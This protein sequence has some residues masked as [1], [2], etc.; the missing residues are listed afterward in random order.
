MTARVDKSHSKDTRP[1]R[2]GVVG[3]GMGRGHIQAYQKVTGC[4]VTAV[5]DKDPDR[6]KR[7]VEE[8]H[9]K[10]T[11]EDAQKMFASGKIDVVS[12]ATP[13]FT[14]RSLTIAAL[15]AGL[16]VLCEKPLAMNAAEAREMLEA[17]K[18]SRR[19]L[20]IHF[21]HRM[22]P[23]AWT[24][25]QF[26][27]A[28]EL[29][30]PSLARA[31]WHRRRGIPAGATGWFR[32]QQTAGGGPLIDLGVHILDQVLFAFDYPRV[33]S[34]T[35]QTVNHFGVEDA[36][37]GMDVE[38]LVTAYI[39]CVNGL[40]IILEVSWAAH[41]EHAEQVHIALYGSKA[42]IVRHQEFYKDEPVKI[43]HRRG[44]QL[45]TTT[46]DTLASAPGV[47]QDFIDAIHEDREPLCSG[48]HGLATMRIID[49]IY[50]SARTG[51]EVRLD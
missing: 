6:L 10:H 41:H 20:A 32:M 34:V 15:Q 13:N 5:C 24:I 18:A 29:G 28:G 11:F 23:Q 22:G 39:R 17:A 36:P 4:E 50:E 40:V 8:F 48:E 1:L 26:V 16:H 19:K 44:D 46:L 7:A 12:I 30:E 33:V 27:K 49:A 3:L 25:A 37:G 38:D 45:A 51:R 35:G 42:G 43:Y 47:H 21:N 31:I 9:I 2:A 14:H